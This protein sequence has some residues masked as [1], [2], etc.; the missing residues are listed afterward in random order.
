MIAPIYKTPFFANG[1]NALKQALFGWQIAGIYNVRTG[2]PFPYFDSTNDAQAGQ[3]YN[4]PRYTPATPITKHTFK[5]T[6]GADGGGDNTYEIG[7]LPPAVSFANPAWRFPDS[8][9]AFLIGDPI[10]PT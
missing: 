4:V 6:N 8:P 3:G 9:M 10:R 2:T 7:K 1:H 5:S